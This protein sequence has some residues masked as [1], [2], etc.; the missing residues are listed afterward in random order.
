MFTC[1]LQEEFWGVLEELHARMHQG[2]AGE[3]QAGAPD[4]QIRT[5]DSAPSGVAS[6]QASWLQMLQQHQQQEDPAT[7]D[8]AAA[9][10]AELRDIPS[11]ATAAAAQ[12]HT[13]NAARAASTAQQGA[14]AQTDMQRP[15]DD[16]GSDKDTEDLF[17]PVGLADRPAGNLQL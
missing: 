4:Q 6:L 15:G 11:A 10:A 2:S 5:A 7:G 9:A 1:L 12:Q 17:L 8:A 13:G 14:V 16:A 3:Q